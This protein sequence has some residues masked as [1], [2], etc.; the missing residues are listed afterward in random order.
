MDARNFII[1]ANTSNIT[2]I[3]NKHG[4]RRINTKRHLWRGV[5]A[6]GKAVEI[7]IELMAANRRRNGNVRLRPARHRVYCYLRRLRVRRMYSQAVRARPEI[8]SGWQLTTVGK[9]G[10]ECLRFVL[11]PNMRYIRRAEEERKPPH[12]A[13]RIFRLRL[14]SIPAVDGPCTRRVAG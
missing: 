9:V 2:V 5:R 12:A 6:V 7:R 8:R 1:F 14:V 11:G 13:K 3:I 10:G 4:L